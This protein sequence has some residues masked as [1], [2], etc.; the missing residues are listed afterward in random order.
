LTVIGLLPATAVS[1][2]IATPSSE[3]LAFDSTGMDDGTVT[4]R[5]VAA[6]KY[7]ISMVNWLAVCIPGV[8]FV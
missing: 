2:W 1:A 5:R 4:R 3:V 8:A 6:I 7:S